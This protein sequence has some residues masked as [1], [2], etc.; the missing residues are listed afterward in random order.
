MG[1]DLLAVDELAFFHHGRTLDDQEEFYDFLRNNWKHQ[2]ASFHLSSDSLIF[3]VLDKYIRIKRIDEEIDKKL[4]GN[5]TEAFRKE[6]A[7][8][9][10][11]YSFY[12]VKRK[13]KDF[14]RFGDIFNLRESASDGEAESYLLNITAHCDCL[15]PDKTDYH[16]HFV[17]G[18]IALPETA[19]KYATSDDY[20]FSFFYSDKDKEPRCISWEKKPFTIFIS[21]KK[22]FFSRNTHIKVKIGKKFKYLF[23][24]GTLLENYTQRIANKSFA[25]ASRVGVDLAELKKES[26]KEAKK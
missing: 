2:L 13:E 26:K 4:K 25:H 14:I 12:H 10:Y 5:N 16:F 20:C 17:R 8:L 3:P 15:K 22:R 21:K 24:E 18:T 11:Q 7:K 23:Y 19:L 9:N 6:L 1:K